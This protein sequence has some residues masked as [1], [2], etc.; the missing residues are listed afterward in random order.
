MEFELSFQLEV[1]NSWTLRCAP[2]QP[3][4]RQW[5]CLF[6]SREGQ[7]PKVMLYHAKP[8][9]EGPARAF[10]GKSSRRQVALSVL[11]SILWSGGHTCI[12]LSKRWVILHHFHIGNFHSPCKTRL[13][14]KNQWFK[15]KFL[16]R[17]DTMLKMT[18]AILIP[19]FLYQNF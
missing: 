7:K 15:N 2:E 5:C 4:W 6:M 13:L 18:C 19:V 1:R 12:S 8:A 11:V 3:G 14:S 17:V 10:H 9:A 16:L